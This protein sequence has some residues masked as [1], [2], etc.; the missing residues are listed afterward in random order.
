MLF[1]IKAKLLFKFHLLFSYNSLKNND[2]FYFLY[3]SFYFTFDM[4]RTNYDVMTATN[5]HSLSW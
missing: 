3:V 5:Q 4:S 2:N 1:A